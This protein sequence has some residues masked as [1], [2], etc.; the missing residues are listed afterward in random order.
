[1]SDFL[2]LA[3]KEIKNLMRDRK[4]IFGLIIVPLIV[5]P[6]LGKMMQ[7]G[8]ESAT[9][10]THVAIV[11]F[12]DGKYGELLIRALNVTP[13]VTVTVISAG[14]VD[15]ALRKALQENQNVLVVIP[16]NFSESIE[17]DE[18]ATVQI[19]GVFK[20]IGSGMRE[21]VSEGRI[22]AVINVL[23]E[24]IA[25][26][27]VQELGAKNPDAVLHPIRAESK[28][29]LLGRIVDVP[30]TVVSQVLASQSYGLPL[31]VF[32]MV[33][34]TSQMSAGAVASEKENKTL[35]TLLTLP[36]R[37]TTIV[38]SK[39]TGTAV[40]GVIAALAYMI[41]LKQYM[42]GFGTQTGVSLSELGLSITPA[43]MALFGVVV[44]LT[45]AFS[46]SLAMLLAVFAEDVQS[47]NTVVSSVILPLAFPSFVLMFVDISQLPALWK[48][49][50]FAS[51]FT[52]PVVDYRYLIAKDYTALGAS[53]AYLAIVAG[54]TLYV[55]A[56]VFASEKI[57]TARLGWGRR[58]GRE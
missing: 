10:T 49:L 57:L 19:Y 14:S 25:K 46:L 8:F 18:V 43:G 24:E 27:K 40:M 7:F 33:M 50:L 51:P 39:I 31:I 5:Y 30:P 38:A 52:H 55:T 22:N 1:M 23:S 53:I 37:R 13:N 26:L 54:A 35:E 20:E 16:H 41:G 36:V 28:S 6:A 11:N 34:I 32:L 15:D 48:Y 44:F 12:D 29:Y 56:R 17:S 45:I 2:V 3:K 4:L 58:K 47:A 42:A 9:K 21:S